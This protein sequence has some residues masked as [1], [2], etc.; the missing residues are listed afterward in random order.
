M[1]SKHSRQYLIGLS[2]PLIFLIC[3]ITDAQSQRPD[4][5]QLIDFYQATAQKSLFNID[6]WKVEVNEQTTMEGNFAKTSPQKYTRKYIVYRDGDR[7]DTRIVMNSFFPDQIRETRYQNVIFGGRSY[8]YNRYVRKDELPKSLIIND[9]TAVL[10]LNCMGHQARAFSGYMLGDLKSLSE[11]LVEKSSEITVRPSMEVVNGYSTYVLEANTQY[12]HYT[13]WMDPNCGYS[14]RRVVIERGEKGMLA[15]QPHLNLKTNNKPTDKAT[16]PARPSVERTTEIM[17]IQKIQ[18]INGNYFAAAGTTTTTRI[19]FNGSV[20]KFNRTCE[21][22]L[23]DFN[24]DFNEIPG[25]FIPDVPN[26]TA[27][28]DDNV[29]DSKFFW[30]DGKVVSLV[31]EPQSLLGKPLPDMND[32]K[33]ALSPDDIKDKSLL[34]Y[35][36]DMQQRPSRNRLKQ[37]TEKAE[38]LK[39]KDIIILAIQAVKVDDKEFDNWLK[40]NNIPFAAGKIQANQEKSRIVWGI[41]SLPWLILTDTQHIVHAEGFAQ[42]ELDEKIKD[43]N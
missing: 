17:D 5:K 39:E 27:V 13:V 12:G 30:Q 9:N 32:L 11:I 41:R 37:L 6:R 8:F 35:F 25:V 14:P 16:R 28:H 23:I 1:K 3:R 36:F 29:P 33:I 43:D 18:K 38:E 4:S 26:G 40:E 19:Y 22:S 24:P 42:D 15:I 7:V 2:V 20:K 31:T 10:F 34:V 21:I